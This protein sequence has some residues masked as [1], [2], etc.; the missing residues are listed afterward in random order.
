VETKLNGRGCRDF[1]TMSRLV[2]TWSQ[3]DPPVELAPQDSSPLPQVSSHGLETCESALTL[4]DV[5]RLESVGV[6]S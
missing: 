5:D 4:Q 6:L 2:V 3:A 1:L